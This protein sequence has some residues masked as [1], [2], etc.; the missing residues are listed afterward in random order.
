MEA[1]GSIVDDGA[2]HRWAV[3][4]ACW[5]ATAAEL[6]SVPRAGGEV[7]RAREQRR[8]KVLWQG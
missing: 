8:K 3:V 7:Q 5:K 6:F 2:E 1:R 4:P